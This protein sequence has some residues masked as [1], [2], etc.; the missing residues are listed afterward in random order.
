MTHQKIRKL[1]QSI[2]T[3]LLLPITLWIIASPIL[4]I[5][6]GLFN[7]EGTRQ[8]IRIAIGIW[9]IVIGSSFFF[10]RAYCGHLCPITG[11]FTWISYLTKS[12]AVM[13]MKYPKMMKYI[14]L[15]LW[16]LSFIV[17]SIGAVSS[18]WGSRQYVTIYSTPEVMIYYGLYF[19]SALLSLTY[20]KSKT[21]HYICPFS[22]WMMAGIRMSDC[23][24]IPSLKIVTDYT[25]C[26]KCKKCNKQC[27]M[28]YDVLK[29]VQEGNFDQAECINCG[30]CVE[31][32]K[33]K[34]IQYSW[35]VKGE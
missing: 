18:K 15:A 22:P 27:S 3:V 1:V 10:Q 23:C 28:G 26:K 8:M 9:G 5:F 6:L 7:F 19:I 20:G 34:A 2:S 13:T 12:K 31:A 14:V 24:K 21:E 30:A 11:V 35:K 16:I 4:V 32:C 17:V 33:F 29:K 25:K